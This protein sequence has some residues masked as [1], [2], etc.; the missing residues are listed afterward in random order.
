MSKKNKKKGTED[1]E[2]VVY[3]DDGS[4][5]SDM[6]NVSSTFNTV[7]PKNKTTREVNHIP[8]KFGDKWKTYWSTVRLM[9][10]PMVVVLGIIFLLYCL[11]MLVPTCAA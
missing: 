10:I 5:I 4:T 6:S 8:S 11:V 1:R 2:K 3:Y 7:I 9:I